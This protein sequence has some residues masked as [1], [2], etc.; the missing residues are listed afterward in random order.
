MT[1]RNV[2][3]VRIHHKPFPLITAPD[4]S[5]PVRRFG[6]LGITLRCLGSSVLFPVLPRLCLTGFNF[7]QPFLATSLIAYFENQGPTTLY[8]GYG[9][10]GASFFTYTGIAISTGWYWHMSYKYGTKLRGGLIAKI[11]DKLMRLKQ[12]TGLESKV[13]TLIIADVD[14]IIS[15]S[16]Y[17]HE[18]WAVVLETGLAAWLLWRQVGPSSLTVLAVAL[19]CAMGSAFLGKHV[20]KA[21]QA[22]LAGT[23]KR[24][25][26]T[27]KN[28][29]F[30]K[31]N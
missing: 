10:I 19:I 24:I 31:G 22:W 1:S 2:Q 8:A 23:E 12:E 6:L 5:Y 29:V 27:K 9:L 26:A 11:S 7:A 17:I 15:A 14:K 21:Q 16:A 28:A 13:F 30:S 25:A 20:G 18:I 3:S 4:L